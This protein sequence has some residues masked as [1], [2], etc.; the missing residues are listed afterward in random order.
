MKR[1]FIIDTTLREG[2]Q[3]PGVQWNVPDS[4]KV[5]LLLKEA[6]VDTIEAGH[7]IVSSLEAER[8][9][10][11]VKAV[12]PIPVLAHARALVGDVEAVASCGVSWVGIFAGVNEV[13][14]ATRMNRSLEEILERIRSSVSHARSLGL[15]VRYTVEDTSRTS[16]DK[17][18]KA[19]KV[20]V[21]AGADRICF[22]DTVGIL[23]PEETRHQVAYLK[24][25]FP[26][27]P[28]EVH[29]HNDRGL[30]MANSLAAAEAGVDW[31]SCSVNGIGERCGIT[32]T[33]TLIANLAYD[34]NLAFPPPGALMQLSETVAAL[35]GV[36]TSPLAPIVGQNAF[37]HTAKLHVT[38][39]KRSAAAYQWLEPKLL[40]RGMEIEESE[41]EEESLA[42]TKI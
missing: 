7:P 28:L 35:S 24:R 33:C 27:I 2:N 4:L 22:S 29:L 10:Q 21:D 11:L 31:I 12:S 6:G 8:V 5:G 13:S 37:R 25:K 32:E 42:S 40:G 19:Y 14:Q 34:G 1:V 23:T 41:T 20:A 15:K 39:V 26:S 9:K 16:I 3:T 38:A 18:H 30:A 36:V 17:I